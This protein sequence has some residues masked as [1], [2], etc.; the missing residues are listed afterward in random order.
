MPRSHTI[1]LALNNVF[2][3]GG[4]LANGGTIDGGTMWQKEGQA[5]RAQ[6][7]DVFNGTV[8]WGD[9]LATSDNA[10]ALSFAVSL[11]SETTF[12]AFSNPDFKSEF[13]LFF[14]NYWF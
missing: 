13:I 1:A 2:V 14:D 4:G 11:T 9:A 7:L 12:V 10:R 6:R 8:V 3:F 5:M